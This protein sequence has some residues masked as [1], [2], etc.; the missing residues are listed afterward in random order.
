MLTS[1]FRLLHLSCEHGRVR[2]K[3]LLRR[4]RLEEVASISG[5]RSACFA[6]QLARQVQKLAEFLAAVL[7]DQKSDSEQLVFHGQGVLTL[8][9]SSDHSAAPYS[10][11]PDLNV[12]QLKPDSVAYDTVERNHMKGP[13]PDLTL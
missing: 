1:Q 12:F 2:C 5:T 3:K 13:G 4:E 7:P 11:P 10:P 8:Q 9:V 6:R